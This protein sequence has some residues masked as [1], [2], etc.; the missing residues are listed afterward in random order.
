[1]YSL[2][3]LKAALHSRTV[4]HTSARARSPGHPLSQDWIQWLWW[5]PTRRHCKIPALPEAGFNSCL[6]QTPTAASTGQEGPD[7]GCCQPRGAADWSFPGGV[8][9]CGPRGTK[10]GSTHCTPSPGSASRVLPAP[11]RCTG[12]PLL[13]GNFTGGLF[14][15]GFSPAGFFCEGPLLATGRARCHLLAFTPSPWHICKY[16]PWDEI[17]QNYVSQQGNGMPWDLCVCNPCKSGL[18]AQCINSSFKGNWWLNTYRSQRKKTTIVQC[19]SPSFSS[20]HCI[21]CR[22]TLFT[23]K[24][25]ALV[26]EWAA[27]EKYSF[28]PKVQIFN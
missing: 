16:L 7:M 8:Q 21:W 4:H 5:A 20:A 23:F 27:K 1:M 12:R 25:S 24:I 15:K 18:G 11:G 3:N 17:W 6:L 10:G 14:C 9:P 13:G 2:V 19:T 22:W 28:S 26:E